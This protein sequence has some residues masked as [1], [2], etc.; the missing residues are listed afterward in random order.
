MEN[1]RLE[2]KAMSL[3]K[4]QNLQR[5][6]YL[7]NLS[8]KH[9]RSI[10]LTQQTNPF[11]KRPHSNLFRQVL[12]KIS[13]QTQLNFKFELVKQKIINSKQTKKRMRNR[14]RT[15]EQGTTALPSPFPSSV[16]P[17][18]LQISSL[19]ALLPP[20]P[21]PNHSPFKDLNITS[22]ITLGSPL[23]SVTSCGI[24]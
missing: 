18:P 15:P 12:R 21:P 13:L 8:L 20:P 1:K 11:H 3:K 6:N 7:E 5:K 2:K 24:T 22:P 16:L 17:P 19:S 14:N 10:M 9:K 4:A 23:D